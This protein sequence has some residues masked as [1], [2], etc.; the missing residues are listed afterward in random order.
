MII[1]NY[2]KHFDF[3]LLRNFWNIVLIKQ[4]SNRCQ[5]NI[6]TGAALKPRDDVALHVSLRPQ[7]HVIVRNHCQNGNW[8]SEERF[9][10]C[11]IGAN[12]LFD[13]VIVAEATQFKILINNTHFCTFK[14]RLA[15]HMA[16]YISISGG[17][18]IQYM[19]IEGGHAGP[20]RPP[21][22]PVHP[23]VYHP[24]IQVSIIMILN[25]LTFITDLLDLST[26]SPDASLSSPSWGWHGSPSTTATTLPRI[27]SRTSLRRGHSLLG[28]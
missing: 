15:I 22:Y 20:G 16:N 6:Q 12:Q 25:A 28:I 3:N 2:Q 9:G 10:G 26:W 8:G 21:I 23:P 17:C 7:E 5:I 13:L 4:F 19:G 24:P 1:H 18:E 11:P 14:Y 27:C